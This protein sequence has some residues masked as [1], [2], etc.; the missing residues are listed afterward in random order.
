MD[1]IKLMFFRK[2]KIDGKEI[3]FLHFLQINIRC[4]PY[5]QK[6]LMILIKKKTEDNCDCKSFVNI[7]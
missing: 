2:G 5:C 6:I 7:A 1:I 3:A 4:A